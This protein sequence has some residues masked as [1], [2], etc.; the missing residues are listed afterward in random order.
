[1]RN[2]RRLLKPTGI[3]LAV[4]MFI[5]SGPYQSAMAAMIGTEVAID[6]GQAQNAREYLN[7]F[8]ARE[9]V[10]NALISQGIDPQEAK[11]RLAG[12]TD[13]EAQRVADQLEQ[14]PAGGDFLVTLLVIVFLVFVIL[15]LTDIAGYTDIFPFVKK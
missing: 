4:F 5:L 2:I 11:N 7:G 1:M 15:L 3:F 9:D 10:R 14:L 8:L 6:A 13:E 12:L